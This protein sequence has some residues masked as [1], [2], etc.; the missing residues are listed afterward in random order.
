M[1]LMSS[2][3]A[4][5]QVVRARI[6]AWLNVDRHRSA[7]S[8]AL[9]AGI[10]PT[11]VSTIR[12]GNR[13][14][15]MKSLV[16]LAAALETSITELEAE[17]IK[18]EREH[19]LQAVRPDPVI[20]RDDPYPNLAEAESFALRAGVGAEAIKDVRMRLAKGQQDMSMLE[21]FDQIR[22]TEDAVRFARRNPAL[23]HQQERARAAAATAEVEKARAAEGFKQ[24]SE[25]LAAEKKKAEQ[26]PAAPAAAKPVAKAPAKKKK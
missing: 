4:L 7:A 2:A 12:S 22:R 13:G 23:V 10:T 19:P 20:A 21:W 5:Q 8:L 25:R 3:Y 9:M 11:H 14:V 15:G 16:G 17:A 24:K 6:E 1:H 26:A 18:W